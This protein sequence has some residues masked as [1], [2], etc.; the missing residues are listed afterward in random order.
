MSV[1]AASI[2]LSFSRGMAQWRYYH[3]PMSVAYYFEAHE[4]T[5]V[6]NT[7]G[8]VYIP[9]PRAGKKNRIPESAEE[10]FRVDYDLIYPFN[11]T[12]CVGKDWH[13]FPGHYLVPDGV[14]I[15]WIKSEFDAMLPGHF[16][17]TPRRGG[18]MERLKGTHA[19]PSGLNDLNNEEPSFY[20]SLNVLRPP[21]V[22]D[23]VS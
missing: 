6:L 4:I 14:R 23:H 7:T 20:V 3:A 17:S 2:V 13:R 21:D 16:Q 8:L 10:E 19:V 1:V 9:P 5:R 12:L 15:E 22:T 18:L 11:L